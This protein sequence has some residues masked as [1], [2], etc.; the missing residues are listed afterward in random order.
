MW[1]TTVSIFKTSDNI[2]KLL[3]FDFSSTGI[4]KKKKKKKKKLVQKKNFHEL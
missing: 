2:S 4:R 1:E 3:S